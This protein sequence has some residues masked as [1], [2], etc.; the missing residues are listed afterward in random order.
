MVSTDDDPWQWLEEIDS[1]AAM[2]WVRARN[3]ETGKLTATEIFGGLRSQIHE[4][5]A[6]ERRISYPTVHGEFWYSYWQDTA[7]PRGLWRRTTVDSYRCDEPQWDILLNLDAL[8][9]AEDENWVCASINVRKPDYDRALIGLSRGGGDAV[10]IR[11]FD[12]STRR[13]VDDG[14]TVPEAKTSITWVDRDLVLVASDFGPG[15]LTKSGYARTVRSW[16]RGTPLDTAPIVYEGGV[17]D[18]C[19]Y[20]THQP[21]PGYV[22]TFLSRRIDF[23]RNEHHLLSPDGTV[24]RLDLPD[25]SGWSIHR[26]WLTI[27]LRSPWTP[28]PTTYPAGALLAT[29]LEPFL[30]G[31]R[32]MVT[33]FE[34][35]PQSALVDWHWTRHHL[36]LQQMVD[37]TSRLEILTPAEPHW[38]RTRIPATNELGWA[39]IQDTQPDDNDDY[40]IGEY[41]FLAPAELRAAIVGEPPQVLKRQPDQFDI[42][43]MRVRQLFAI[44]ADGTQVPYFVIGDPDSVNPPTLIWAYG[45]FNVPSTPSYDPVIG[46]TWLA[47]GGT[48]VVANIRGGG[49]YGPGWHEAARG[50]Q[51][52]KAFEDLAA[53]AEDLAARGITTLV[54]LGMEGRSNGGLL[55]GVMYTRYPHL[56][57]AVIAEVPLLD[58]RS[59]HT[60]LAGASWTAEYGD[61]DNPDDWAYLSQYSPYHNIQPSQKYPPLLLITSTRDDRVHPGHARKMAARLAEHGCDVTYYEN[62][63]GGHAAAADHR[64]QAHNDA[65]KIQFLWQTLA[66]PA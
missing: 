22:R 59:F 11:E 57:G 47:R 14:F 53:I 13:F 50:H 2:D 51:R 49:E 66:G 54:R 48:Y 29:R 3:A 58:M 55:A 23:Y 35:S 12:L 40:L 28:G 26:E 21:T 8:A 17:D 18:V 52:H 63:D 56:F 27:W 34:P 39:W 16:R 37:V 4:I 46:A 62:I 60:L 7:Y 1:E 41:S 20:A 61:P 24:V 42:T 64:Q 31:S 32:D 33:L 5:L 25:D 9:A 65:L 10:V 38:A 30:T 36:I 19:V 6:D 15:S 43:G 45:G 44:S